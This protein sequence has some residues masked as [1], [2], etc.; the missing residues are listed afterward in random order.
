VLPIHPAAELFPMMSEQELR[1]LGDDIRKR[2]LLEGVAVLDGKLLDGRNRLDA[3]ELVGIKLVTGNGQL[4]W[5]SIPC[6][7]VQGVNPFDYVVSKN[8]HRR[9]LSLEQKAELVA[10]LLTA[11]PENSDRQIAGAVKASPSTVGKIRQRLEKTGDVSKL[12]TRTDS[13]GRRQHA[14]KPVVKKPRDIEDYIAEKNARMTATKDADA[15]RLA[16]HQTDPDHLISQFSAQV[17]STGLDIAR[18]IEAGLVQTL[19]EHWPI[20]W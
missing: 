1:D 3:M 6:R 19:D 15:P 18:Q 16:P 13:K 10:K 4:D 14:H 7:N 9:H 5:A 12:D 17:R 20:R 2:G 8:F 11:T